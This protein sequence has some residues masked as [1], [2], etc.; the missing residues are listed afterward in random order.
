MEDICHK[1]GHQHRK[2]LPLLRQFPTLFFWVGGT[3]HLPSEKQKIS[4]PHPPCGFLVARERVSDVYPAKQT[5]AHNQ[6]AAASHLPPPAGT[7]AVSLPGC[8]VVRFWLWSWQLPGH[9]RPYLILRQQP[10]LGLSELL[11]NL[12]K[13]KKARIFSASVNQSQSSSWGS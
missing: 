7:T 2:R 8:S 1:F 5:R 11:N 6:Q 12:E 9:L 4:G 13:R 3:A 10:S